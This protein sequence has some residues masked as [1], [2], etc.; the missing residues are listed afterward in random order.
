MTAPRTDDDLD[1]LIAARRKALA[2]PDTTHAGG[3]AL[4]TLIAE[5]R[6]AAEHDKPSLSERVR[7]QVGGAVG[8]FLA[9][10]LD[11]V[12]SMIAAPVKSAIDAV[13]TPEEGD[14]RPDP[15]LSKGGNASGR[16]IELTPYDREHGAQ[17]KGGR[18]VA[19]VQ[20]MTNLAFPSVASGVAGRLGGGA[21][22]K[23][24][25]LAAAGAGSGAAYTPNDPVAGA[26]TGAILAPG[27]HGVGKGV[28]AIGRGMGAI[29]EHVIDLKGRPETSRPL[30]TLGGRGIGQIE[31]V[32][33]RATRLNRQA[34]PEIPRPATDKPLAPVDLGIEAQRLARGLKTASPAAEKVLRGALDQRAEGAVDRV[35]QHGLETTGLATRESGLQ[36]VDDLIAQRTEHGRENFEPTFKAHPNPIDDPEF[37]EIAQ[38]PAGQQALKRGMTIAANRG[39]KIGTVAEEMGAPPGI[40]ADDWANMQRIAKERGIPLPEVEGTRR[41]APTLRQAHYIKLGFDDML[42]S[43]PEPGSGG[44]GPNNAGAIR[45]LKKRWL[46]AMDRHSEKYAADRKTF[47]DESDLIR[48]GEVGRK[49]FAMHPDEAKKAFGEMSDAERDVARRTGFDALAYRVE[50]GPADVERGVSKPRDQ[51]RMRLLFPD[52]ASFEKWREGLKQEAQMHATKQGVLGG[53]NTADKIADMAGMAGVSLP[54]VLSAAG[55]RWKPLLVKGTKALLSRSRQESMDRLAA[56]RARQLV[57]GTQGRP[58]APP[59]APSPPVSLPPLKRLPPGRFESG[60]MQG[61][62]MPIPQP[63]PK[64][65]WLGP[66]VTYPTVAGEAIHGTAMPIPQPLPMN[67]RLPSGGPTPVPTAG[68]GP[69]GPPIPA[70]GATLEQVIREEALR[71]YRKEPHVA[72][73]LTPDQHNAFVS[74]LRDAI[75]KGRDPSHVSLAFNPEYWQEASPGEVKAPEPRARTEAGRLKSLT[76][77]SDDELAGEYA[78]LV[79]ANASENTAPSSREAD[80]GSAYYQWVGQEKGAAH[81]MGRI[82]MR[83]KSIAKIE[84][85]LHRRGIDPIEAYRRAR[86]GPEEGDEGDASFDF[87]ANVR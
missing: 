14:A 57:A 22:A 23:A 24:A 52:D 36:T 10:P 77:A 81:A 40:H 56:E 87:G 2:A 17:P 45:Q 47:A 59:A 68:A 60:D 30:V 76:R 19:A 15:R 79:D 82:A 49:L 42:N 84:A 28:G 73:T 50:N 38:T 34:L 31:G 74:E 44:S 86:G 70:S 25:G 75:V 16:P 61:T 4:D 9:H 62:A 3:D 32:Q 13:L 80:G 26:V 11:T 83:K 20:T 7:S 51:A 54:D 37:G 21:L 65:R 67:R 18:G 1:S 12:G 48:A 53:S 58:A 69:L 27:I 43:A 8:E 39:E 71:R 6:A 64:S 35:I 63:V 29:G 5:R 66:G 55:G 41:I 85:E 72:V 78:S 46:A 33:E